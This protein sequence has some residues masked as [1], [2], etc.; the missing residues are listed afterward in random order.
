[1][2]VAGF[3]GLGNI[4]APMAKCLLGNPDGLVVF[5]VYAPST[6]PFAEAGATVAASLTEVAERADVIGICVR[7]DAQVR[8][9]VDG[10]LAAARSGQV[11]MIHST[12]RAATAEELAALAEP[13][14]V[15]VIDAAV[16]GG[17]VGAAE[18]K[19][20]I[21]VG[22][23]EEGFA[24][25]KPVLRQMGTLVRHLGP[26]GAG[27]RAKL[28]RN[29]LHFVSFTA[30]AEA[31]RLA[32]AAGIDLNVLGQIVRHSDGLTGGAG[33]VMLRPTTDPLS[34]D[35][36]LYG[37][38]RMAAE[39]GLKDLTQAIE[40]ADELGVDTPLARL[41]L[42]G[43]PTALGVPDVGRPADQPANDSEEH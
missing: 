2:A 6:E 34:A 29:L 32:E 9:V 1:M 30:T 21:M 43:L 37:P 13:H 16:S 28:A 23:S 31:S 38:M 5:D 40:L 7:D 20:A 4:G 25:A 3:V 17:A 35:D 12:V 19:L 14:G 24:T 18:G 39:L 10:L 11:Y 27:T 8:E 41:A 15:S 33:A 22:G 36:W 42:E 26:A